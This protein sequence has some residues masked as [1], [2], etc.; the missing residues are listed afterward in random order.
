MQPRGVRVKFENYRVTLLVLLLV[1]CTGALFCDFGYG[2]GLLGFLTYFYAKCTQNAPSRIQHVLWWFSHPRRILLP[3][4]YVM[5]MVERS[6]PCSW[7]IRVFRFCTQNSYCRGLSSTEC[8]LYDNSGV[9]LV[10]VSVGV[11]IGIGG[12]VFLIAKLFSFCKCILWVLG[13]WASVGHNAGG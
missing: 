4:V 12:S 11:S 5:R 6:T 13:I 1:S 7:I 3:L 9:V 8:G 2:D 10:E